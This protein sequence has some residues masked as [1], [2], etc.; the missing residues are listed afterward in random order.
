MNFETFL[1]VT[2][3]FS[4]FTNE[5]LM[6]LEKSMRV[7][8]YPV[9]HVFIEEENLG[10][11]VYLIIDGEVSVSHKR[12]FKSGWLEIERLHS[13]EWFGLVSATDSGIHKTTYTAATKVTVAS[14]P[15]TAFTLLYNSNIE[16][17]YKLQKLITYQVLRDH[18]SLLSLIRKTMTTIENSGESRNVLDMIYKENLSSERRSHTERRAE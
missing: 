18:R 17:A 14:L 5:D 11:D 1:Q 8:I 9:D 3:E 4:D 6:L 16:L 2:D 7:D 13:A 10:E 15:K 12:G